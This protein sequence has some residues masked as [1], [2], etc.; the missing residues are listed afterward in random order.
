VYWFVLMGSSG[1]YSDCWHFEKEEWIY[2]VVCNMCM[3]LLDKIAE[4]HAR[5]AWFL[6]LV[7]CVN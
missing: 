7:L 3:G 2:L 1:E 6:G 5:S 4:R